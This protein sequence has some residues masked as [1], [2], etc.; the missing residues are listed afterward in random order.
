MTSTSSADTAQAHSNRWRAIILR[1]PL[2]SFFGLA[3]GISWL[4]WTPYVLSSDGLGLLHFRYPDFLVGNQLTAILPGAY[5]GPLTAAFT[6]T[7]LTEGRAGLRRWRRRLFQFR[8]GIWWYVLALVGVPFAIVAGTLAMDGA[9]DAAHLPPVMVLAAYLPMLVLQFFTTGLAEEPGW[10]DFALTRL[11]Q[12]HHPLMATT[13]LGVLWAA[14]HLPLFLTP[15]GGPDVGPE[16]IGRFFVVA[17]A[18]SFVMTLV[19]NKARQSVPLIM[20]LHANFNNFMSVAWSEIFPGEHPDWQW[21]PALGVGLLA[22]VTIAA[23]RG[24]LGAKA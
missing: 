8:A 16:V 2:I 22:I 19:F 13:I 23:T 7:A 21:G 6:V 24:R 3:F 10:R 15:W 14:W 20:L 1:F 18:L 9:E 11:Q 5:L 12:R 4:A 17:M